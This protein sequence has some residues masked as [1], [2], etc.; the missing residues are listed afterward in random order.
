MHHLLHHTDTA[1]TL[2]PAKPPAKLLLCID[3]LPNWRVIFIQVTPGSTPSLDRMRVLLAVTVCIVWVLRRHH[4]VRHGRGAMAHMA[5][6]PAHRPCA[7]EWCSLKLINRSLVF[8]GER[9]H[10]KGNKAREHAD[11]RHLAENH[12]DAEPEAEVVQRRASGDAALRDI[13]RK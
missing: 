12:D 1:G 9:E 11:Q 7:L 6:G 13:T 5:G 10:T 2:L 4:I 3:K 8:V